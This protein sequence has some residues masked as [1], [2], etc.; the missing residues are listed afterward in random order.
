MRTV[1]TT[2][3]RTNFP[4]SHRIATTDQPHHPT[5][6]DTEQR[7]QGEFEMSYF[8]TYQ[9]NP[10]QWGWANPQIAQAFGQQGWGVGG[11]GQG[12]AAYGQ[13]FGQFGGQ[14]FGQTNPGLWG[15]G[16]AGR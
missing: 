11:Q 16:R 14:Q 6:A 9:Q 13:P 2:A 1:H 5:I 15:Q 3:A 10:Q 12:Q 7:Q 8:E 4:Y